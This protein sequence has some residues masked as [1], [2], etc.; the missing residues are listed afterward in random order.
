MN[1]VYF[2]SGTGNSRALARRVAEG[3]APC[4]CIEI[5]KEFL[6]SEPAATEYERVLAVFPSYAYGIPALVRQFLRREYFRSDYVA[7]AATCGTSAGGTLATAR[8]LLKKRG[9]TVSL[10]FTVKT[11][12]NFLPIFGEQPEERILIRIENQK[13]LADELID[14]LKD[15]KIRKIRRFHP[16]AGCVNGVF[17]AAT[18][19]LASSI[20]IGDACTGCGV[21]RR[22]CPAAAIEI[23]EGK[24]VIDRKRCNQC[25]ACLNACPSQAMRMW[26]HKNGCRQYLH[27]DIELRELFKR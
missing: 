4:D 25:Q 6:E 24:P 21:C 5:T 13:R 16:L 14:A 1:A 8:K 17:R 9:V 20:R 11:V 26:R 12:E 3:L 15:K 10:G 27:P 2:F 22:V 18:P 19:L 7:L 23:R